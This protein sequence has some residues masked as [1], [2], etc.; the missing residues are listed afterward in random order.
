MITVQKVSSYY[1]QSPACVDISFDAY[2][3]EITALIGRN[4]AGKSTLLK[5]LAGIRLPSSGSIAICGFDTVHSPLEAKLHLGYVSEN[6]PLYP[7]MTIIEQLNFSAE[8]FGIPYAE[9]DKA[10]RI[11]IER[12]GLSGIAGRRI[13]TLSRGYRQRTAIVNALI[14]NPSVLLLDEAATGLDPVQLPEFRHMLAELA[15]DHT[16]VFSTHSIHDAE[17]LASQVLIM[18]HGKL[19]GRGTPEEIK[20]QSHT[21]TLE[22]A[23]LCITHDMTTISNEK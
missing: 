20:K 6:I 22:S 9:G 17:Q 13:G 4:G 19:I 15:T 5:L 2:K 12:Y 1:G 8:M 10:V 14:H 7:D 21:D 3:G 23:F 11:M 18:D 16:I